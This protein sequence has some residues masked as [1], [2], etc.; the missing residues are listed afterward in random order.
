MGLLNFL[1]GKTIKLEHPFFGTLVFYED[2][3]I[4]CKVIFLEAKTLSHQENQL[5]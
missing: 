1:F 5:K 4:L 2:K 3:K